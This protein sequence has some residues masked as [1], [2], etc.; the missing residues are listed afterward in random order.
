V[1]TNPLYQALVEALESQLPP[2]V[3]SVVL[4]EGLSVV[5]A[6]PATLDHDAAKRI[7]KD[8]VLRQLMAGGRSEEVAKAAIVEMNAYLKEAVPVGAPATGTAPPPVAAAAPV[9][10]TPAVE[11]ALAELQAAL[12]PLNIYF[13]WSEVR[14]LRSLAQLAEDEARVGGDATPL[15]REAEAQLQLVE[16]KLEDHLVLQAQVLADLESALE[17]VTPLGT[18]AVRR[19][20]ALVGTVRD[21]QARRTL[22][23]AEVERAEKLAR[24]LRKLVESTVLDDGSLPD[25]GRGDGRPRA[26]ALVPLADR[27]P[28]SPAPDGADEAPAAPPAADAQ[29]RL[30]A[31]EVQGEA[32]D[33]HGLAARHAELLRHVPFLAEELASLRAEHAAGRTVG[34]RLAHLATAWQAQAEARRLAL[35]GEFE[36]VRHELDAFPVEIDVTDLRRALTVALDV[37]HDGLPA[38]EDVAAV[39]ELHGVAVARREE[40]A[41]R[42]R[43]RVARHH[44]HRTQLV[45]AR[46]R[47]DAAWRES[48]GSPRLAAA[49]ERLRAVLDDHVE[50]LDP[51][52]TMARLEAALDAEAAWER[53]VAE[54]SDDQVERWRARTRELAARLAQLPD[55]ANLRARAQAVRQEIAEAESRSGLDEDQVQALAHVVDG[56]VGDA[57]ATM[58]SRLD[59]VAHDAGDPAPP[60]LL[61][62]LQMAARVLEDGGFPDLEDV[63]REVRATRDELS[64]GVRRR[65]L[66]ARQEAHRLA[67]ADVQGT[68]RLEALITDA[69]TAIESDDGGESA[70]ERLER[71]LA[72]VER[73]LA[74]RLEGFGPR[75]DAA[76]D[77]FRTVAR[78]NNDDVAAVRRVLDHLDGQRSAIGRVSPGLQGQLFAALAEAEATLL[79]L[80]TAFEAT[81]AVAD[82]LVSGN[83]IDELLGSFDALFGDDEV[84]ATPAPRR[85]LT[86]WLE[87]CLAVEGVEGA[88]VVGPTG[89]AIAGTAPEGIDLG[90]IGTAL[91]P[92]VDVWAALG[93]HLGDD[94]PELVLI[95]VADRPTWIAPLADLGC[96]LVWSH[97][98]SVG[99]WLRG[100]L[101]DDR[102]D[103]VAL[104][105]DG[106]RSAIVGTD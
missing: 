44:E 86:A 73:H 79:T 89:E 82:Q 77:A 88:V 95:D 97:V 19:L 54:A 37:L 9:A 15:L 83:A 106:S 62:A 93:A 75:L 28:A 24:E 80:R 68:D 39:R 47:L 45:A 20:E 58:A 25:L 29:D 81:R 36:A 78:L 71:Q 32:H 49:R 96:V 63:E 1:I 13:T 7:L 30:R 52:E 59:Q 74:A 53:A 60:A 51:L 85:S 41:Q 33:L 46:R 55:L 101:H 27:T 40:A 50:E 87:D 4:R 23:E 38:V 34:D 64:A 11:A 16:Q 61:R 98:P 104:L 100:R 12:R 102:A 70:V 48:A 6:T 103:L 76:L 21:A 31:L 72:T 56:L 67:G 5:D 99:G 66:R 14:K 22:V 57:R 8:Q 42:D 43:E 69:R 84:A 65:Y 3:V 10:P 35:R 17:T 92:M 2:R 18:T 91:E 90:T 94:L 26:P 105:R